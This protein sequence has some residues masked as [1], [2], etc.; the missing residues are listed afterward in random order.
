MPTIVMLVAFGFMVSQTAPDFFSKVFHARNLPGFLFVI[1]LIFIA[2]GTTGTKEELES[3]SMLAR[4]M[5]NVCTAIGLGCAGTGL[6]IFLKR[7][8]N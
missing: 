7:T 8:C 4:V 2:I 1:G 3:M 6:V 5:L